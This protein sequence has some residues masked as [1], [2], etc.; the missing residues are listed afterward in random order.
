MGKKIIVEVESGIPG[1]RWRV[2][3]GTGK[4][5]I[6][7]LM[8]IISTVQALGPI[9]VQIHQLKEEI[10]RL[11]KQAQPYRQPLEEYVKE[12]PWLRGAKDEKGKYIL[13]FIPRRYW[14]PEVLR[15]YLGRLYY[16]LL[17]KGKLIITLSLP[18]RGKKGYILPETIIKAI[19]D[20]LSTVGGNLEEANISFEEKV[21]EIK[22]DQIEKLQSKGKLPPLP[23]EAREIDVII[24]T[25]PLAEG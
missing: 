20:L 22:E 9:E 24:S 18:L 12:H 2:E 4:E 7:K 16:S 10:K 15:P 23:R 11:E 3:E 13:T 1:V 8:E 19:E 25:E 5:E 21:Y 6:V 17:T 14:K